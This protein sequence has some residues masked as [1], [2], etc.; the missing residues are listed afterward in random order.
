MDHAANGVYSLC[1]VGDSCALA[2]DGIGRLLCYELNSTRERSSR[3]VRAECLRYGLAGSRRGAVR[4]LACVGRSVVAVGE[5]VF[6]QPEQ[7]SVFGKSVARMDLDF[8][9]KWIWIP[10]RPKPLILVFSTHNF[11]FDF[12][13]D[14][15]LRQQNLN[16][17]HSS[18]LLPP[19]LL[20]SFVALV[21]MSAFKRTLQ[22]MLL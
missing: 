12:D 20:L 9:Q 14:Y 2:G 6:S 19:C 18:I 10:F 17:S 22:G 11:N 16:H 21:V 15:P 7:S 13:F 4:G 1:M 8:D 5:D 3:T